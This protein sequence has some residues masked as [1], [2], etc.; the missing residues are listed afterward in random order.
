MKSIGVEGDRG[1]E[2]LGSG[3]LSDILIYVWAVFWSEDRRKD[4]EE[5]IHWEI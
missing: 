1:W 2:S 3:E 4:I 5:V